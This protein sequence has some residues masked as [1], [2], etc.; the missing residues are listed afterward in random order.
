M[1]RYSEGPVSRVEVITLVQRRRAVSSPIG[2][3]ARARDIRRSR[4]LVEIDEFFRIEIQLAVEPRLPSFA[5]SGRSCWI[6]SNA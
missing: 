5:I 1:T 3:S 6:E 2:A 4:F